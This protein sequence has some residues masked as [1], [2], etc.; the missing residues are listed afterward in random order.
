[1]L[2]AEKAGDRFDL[3]GIDEVRVKVLGDPS[4]RPTDVRAKA[5]FN[6]RQEFVKTTQYEPQTA[7]EM[8]AARLQQQAD[9]TQ[10][11]WQ[12]WFV[13]TVRDKK[14]C[15]F[16]ANINFAS[17]LERRDEKAEMTAMTTFMN[18][19]VFAPWRERSEANAA[20]YK[21]Q[22]D[23]LNFMEDWLR[24]NYLDQSDHNSWGIGFVLLNNAGF[25]PQ[26]IPA[27]VAV[28]EPAPSALEKHITARQ[29]YIELV[30]GIDEH[31]KQWTDEM[32]DQ[33]DSKQALRLRRLFETGTRGNS[34]MLTY[35]DVKDAQ[36]QRDLELAKRVLAQ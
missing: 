30:V 11:E 36:A 4:N 24:L 23:I 18:S 27:P 26:P 6:E 5:G 14:N 12:K 34:N 8:K 33:I 9:A 28:P 32:L 15:P 35:L 22:I 1:L 19:D 29:N 16:I 7:E 21:A 25:I 20:R 31:G 13:Q 3:P 10:A 17:T 2:E